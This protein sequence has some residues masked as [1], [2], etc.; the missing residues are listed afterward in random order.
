M[1]M[2]NPQTKVIFILV[3]E[4]QTAALAGVASICTLDGKYS[5]S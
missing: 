5:D 1:G 2:S 3:N 4:M